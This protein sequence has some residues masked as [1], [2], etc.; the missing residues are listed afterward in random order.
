[1][2]T[3]AAMLFVM[4]SPNPALAFTSLCA[5]E[6]ATG[7]NWESGKWV[8]SN[9]FPRQHIVRGTTRDEAI[10]STC[11]ER[12]DREGLSEAATKNSAGSIGSSGCYAL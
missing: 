2:V 9:F 1:M 11:Y 5:E 10:A 7:F 6:G 12:L 3:T 8:K 4:S